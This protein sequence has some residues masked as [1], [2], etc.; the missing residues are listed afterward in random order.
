MM[1][2]FCW[3]NGGG[4]QDMEAER[5]DVDPPVNAIGL[6]LGTKGG[7]ECAITNKTI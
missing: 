2:P 3:F 1:I 4:L 6:P 5:V 7:R